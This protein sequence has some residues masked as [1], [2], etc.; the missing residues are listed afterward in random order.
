MA[1]LSSY[2]VKIVYEHLSI[3]Q[4]YI[5]EWQCCL[6][7]HRPVSLE[8]WHQ[9]KW[10]RCR[11]RPRIDAE[12]QEEKLLLEEGSLNGWWSIIDKFPCDIEK[13]F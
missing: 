3:L 11:E 2:S 7:C 4:T 5:Y 8:M 10:L 6:L 13:C 9:F 12:R 1:T